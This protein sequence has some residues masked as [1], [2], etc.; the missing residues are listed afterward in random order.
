MKT[1][2]NCLIFAIRL[3][4]HRKNLGK[5]GYILMRRNRDPYKLAHF[6]YGEK[7]A[8]GDL[9]VI[10]YLPLDSNTSPPPF[11]FAGKVKWGDT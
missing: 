7:T 2:T 1:R 10:H 5:E 6:L 9:R 4:L 3:F 11:L 8:K